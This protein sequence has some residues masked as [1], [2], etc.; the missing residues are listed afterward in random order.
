MLTRCAAALPRLTWEPIL[1]YST[2]CI[3]GFLLFCIL[4]AAYFEADRIFHTDIIKRRQR[5]LANAYD[6]NKVLDLRSIGASIRAQDSGGGKVTLVKNTGNHGN[7]ELGNGHVECVSNHVTPHPRRKKESPW[8]VWKLWTWGSKSTH[9]QDAPIK[10]LPSAPNPNTRQRPSPSPDVTPS[11]NT[12]SSSVKTVAPTA[13]NNN[14][15][16]HKSA[17]K[18]WFWQRLFRQKPPAKSAAKPARDLSSPNMNNVTSNGVTD[19]RKPISV[20]N[21]ILPSS[22][23]HSNHSNGNSSSSF[24][25][26]FSSSSSNSQKR[27]SANKD[28]NT[29]DNYVHSYIRQNSD[30]DITKEQVRLANQKRVLIEKS[31]SMGLDSLDAPAVS[32]ID[33][34]DDIIARREQGKQ[35]SLGLFAAKIKFSHTRAAICVVGWLYK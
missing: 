13:T 30:N 25:S 27:K 34:D 20:N 35:N 12:N 23:P 4:V 6:K 2:L 3:M 33:E 11:L 32:I 26:V 15:N 8:S 28:N 10:P 29:A 7:S 16:N 18:P 17:P 14:N 22:T 19:V 5:Q 1:F 21:G 31:S 9:S 24:L